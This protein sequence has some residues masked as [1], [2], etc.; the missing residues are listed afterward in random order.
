[1]ASWCNSVGPSSLGRHSPLY[2]ARLSEARIVPFV[3]NSRGLAY[4]AVLPRREGDE[5]GGGGV[6]HGHLF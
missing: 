1:M 2:A 4:S 3:C 5:G 6:V